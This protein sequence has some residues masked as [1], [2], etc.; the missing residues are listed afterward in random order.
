M[1]N[2]PNM[3]KCDM[4]AT[5]ERFM[6][7]TDEFL[8]MG[9]EQLVQRTGCLTPCQYD[10]HVSLRT[11]VKRIDVRRTE[12]KAQVMINTPI[13]FPL[14]PKDSLIVQ[15]TFTGTTYLERIEYLVYG[16]TN[17][18]A[19]VG[20]YLGL[21]LGHSILSLYDLATIASGKGFGFLGLYRDK[22]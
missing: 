20:G 17:F 6:A 9:E 2:D 5:K 10:F 18:I 1:R 3:A 8:K 4:N 12:F 14:W 19:D 22:K 15:F 21:L 16:M 7:L 13:N 11:C